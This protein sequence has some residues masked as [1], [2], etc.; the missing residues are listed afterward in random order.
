MIQMLEL[1]QS[2]RLVQSLTATSFPSTASD[3]TTPYSLFILL[4]PTWT[5]GLAALSAIISVDYMS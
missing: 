2:R 5:L 3:A 4:K 1:L